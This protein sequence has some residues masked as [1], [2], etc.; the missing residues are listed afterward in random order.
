MNGGLKLGKIFGISIEVHHTW[1]IIF[2][3]VTLS[4]SKFY[5][6]T[7]YPNLSNLSY[8]LMGFIASLLLF[9]SVFLHELS[10]SLIGMKNGVPIKKITLFLFGGVAQLAE[11]PR[12]PRVEFMMAVAGPV[13]S[14]LLLILF[15]C[16]CFFLGARGGPVEAIAILKYLAI[17]NG[18]LLFFNLIPGFPLDGGRILRAAIWHKRKDLKFATLITSRI[19]KGFAVFLIIFGFWNAFIFRNTLQGLWLVLI[20]F[21]LQQAADTGYRQVVIKDVLRGIKVKE[22]M[23]K[24]VISVSDSLTLSEAVDRYFLK[25]HFK[26]FPVVNSHNRFLGLI[27]LQNVKEVPSERWL[28]VRIA[29][30]MHRE[31]AQISVHPQEE[32]VEVLNQMIREGIGRMAVIEGDELVGIITRRD[33]MHLLRIKTDLGT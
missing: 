13:C 15:A 24:P 12:N 28:E 16:L 3:V 10:H 30:V 23:K 31:L 25:Y 32:A 27:T 17:I 6:P 2:I 18:V 19:G 11:E 14:F 29:Q 33:I 21:F 20:G 5:F 1:F 8:W 26:S 4:L 9:L 22:M 7:F